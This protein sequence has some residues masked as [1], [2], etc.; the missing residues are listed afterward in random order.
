[1]Y[2]SHFSLDVGFK[3]IT[4]HTIMM[5]Y[6]DDE[7]HH[8]RHYPWR[9]YYLVTLSERSVKRDADTNMVYNHYQAEWEDPRENTQVLVWNSVEKK[10]K[11]VDRNSNEWYS[12]EEN[13]KKIEDSDEWKAAELE[14]NAIEL[15]KHKD[16]RFEKHI[17]LLVKKWFKWLYANDHSSTDDEG[18]EDH[19]IINRRNQRSQRR[20]KTFRKENFSIRNQI[21]YLRKRCGYD[22][23]YE[24]LDF[25]MML[26]PLGEMSSPIKMLNSE[27]IRYRED[28]YE[29]QYPEDRKEYEDFLL[30][31]CKKT[32]I[33][34]D[35]IL[36]ISQ[37]VSLLKKLPS[38]MYSDTFQARHG[39]PSGISDP[40][41]WVS[42]RDYP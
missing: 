36:R 26:M 21:A 40:I 41:H 42:L 11:M 38:E 25:L 27:V 1:M 13:W 28:Q 39:K 20:A 4:T 10:W 35:I 29:K 33:A 22:E 9:P 16:N 2:R 3:N 18:F 6:D 31:L 8:C 37:F 17:N 19:R 30:G 14:W 15:K 12:E 5:D 34:P 7:D 24:F 32:E 23:D